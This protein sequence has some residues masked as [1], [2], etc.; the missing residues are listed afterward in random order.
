[1]KP[2]K[3]RTIYFPEQGDERKACCM[4]R[5]DNSIPNCSQA[6]LTTCR[7]V[8]ALLVTVTSC[9]LNFSTWG[10]KIK[11]RFQVG[12]KQNGNHLLCICFLHTQSSS[13][14][15]FSLNMSSIPTATIQV[16]TPHLLTP[17]YLQQSLSFPALYTAGS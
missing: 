14:K 16:Q 10:Q 13:S 4:F 11:L 17:S 8:M 12:G 7:Q 3:M 6:L 5:A 9:L 1:M 2:Q 15:G